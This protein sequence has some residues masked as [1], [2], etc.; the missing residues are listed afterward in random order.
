[1]SEIPAE[2]FILTIRTGEPT[3]MRFYV[4][5]LGFWTNAKAHTAMSELPETHIKYASVERVPGTG[6]YRL[7][8]IKEV[9]GLWL[10]DEEVLNA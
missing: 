7:G 1:M 4:R 6:A 5:R 8:Y 2:L 3:D 9:G 10:I